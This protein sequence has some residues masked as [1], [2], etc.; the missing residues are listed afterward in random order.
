MDYTNIIAVFLGGGL[1]LGIA[2][3]YKAIS[4]AKEKKGLTEALEA[5]TPADVES[6]SVATMTKALESAQS[7]ITSLE[8]ERDLDKKYYQDRI[9][10]LT[11]Q[12]HRVREEMA[13]M[14]QKLSNLLA[15]THQQV[16]SRRPAS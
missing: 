5:K 9:A 1:F 10:E 15:E 12:L 7:R 14:E 11:E 4:E 6:V 2:A 8:R 16:P 13:E 3:L